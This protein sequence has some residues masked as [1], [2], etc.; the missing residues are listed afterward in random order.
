MA[1]LLP[2]ARIGALGGNR[3]EFDSSSELPVASE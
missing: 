3:R 1:F 2:T